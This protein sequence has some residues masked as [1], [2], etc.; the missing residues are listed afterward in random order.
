MFGPQQGDVKC[1]IILKSKQKKFLSKNFMK[2]H[3]KVGQLRQ[4]GQLRKVGQLR[5]V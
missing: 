4:V 1:T 2:K 3:S 5:H